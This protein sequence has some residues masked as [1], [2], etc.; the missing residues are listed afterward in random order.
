MCDLGG[1]S[2]C[3]RVDTE[4]WCVCVCVCLHFHASPQAG[5]IVITHSSGWTGREIE[6]LGRRPQLPHSPSPSACCWLSLPNTHTHSQMYTC[7]RTHT[8]ETAMPAHAHLCSISLLHTQTLSHSLFHQSSEET[9]LCVAVMRFSHTRPYLPAQASKGWDWVS[10]GLVFVC[11]RAGAQCVWLK[12]VVWAHP[13]ARFLDDDILRFKKCSFSSIIQTEEV[14]VVWLKKK[15][16]GHDFL[17]YIFKEKKRKRTATWL[18]G[19][20]LLCFSL[21]RCVHIHHVSVKR[22]WPAPKL[23]HSW[24]R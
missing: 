6:G 13:A 16:M 9:R 5:P 23:C 12:V 7:T 15:R 14:Q 8:L 18:S 2:G 11:V 3:G 19:I 24:S 21:E 10:E 17:K 1:G 22:L 20:T 4:R